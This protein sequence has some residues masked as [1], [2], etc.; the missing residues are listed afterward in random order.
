MR[1][2]GSRS[3]LP[4]RGDDGIDRFLTESEGVLP[5]PNSERKPLCMVS[6]IL[7]MV[8]ASARIT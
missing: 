2:V 1:M 6:A 5:G 8:S 3:S 7:C 4:Q